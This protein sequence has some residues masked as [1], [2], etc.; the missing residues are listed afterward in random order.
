MTGEDQPAGEVLEGANLVLGERRAP[1]GHGPGHACQDEPDHV[2]GALTPDDLA[3]SHLQIDPVQYVCPRIGE[4]HALEP[5][6]APQ[7]RRG[8]SGAS[9]IHH[10]AGGAEGA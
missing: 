4:V 9:D 10:G 5:H 6:R 7:S 2:A 1:A 3:G 8:A